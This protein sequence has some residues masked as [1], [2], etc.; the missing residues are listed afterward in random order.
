MDGRRVESTKVTSELSF[1]APGPS[2]PP[3]SQPLNPCLHSSVLQLPVRTLSASALE[4]GP[5]VISPPSNV[6]AMTSVASE[7][8]RVMLNAEHQNPTDKPSGSDWMHS[9]QISRLSRRYHDELPQ[10]PISLVAPAENPVS[11]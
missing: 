5:S 9:G 11:S 4:A 6:F 7:S 2:I 3:L 8:C 1:D 10:P